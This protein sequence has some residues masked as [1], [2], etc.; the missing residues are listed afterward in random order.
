VHPAPPKLLA[1]I[2]R[3]EHHA[4]YQNSPKEKV[5]LA[6]LLSPDVLHFCRTYPQAT[7]IVRFRWD[8][9]GHIGKRYARFLDAL[10][11]NLRGSAL[12]PDMVH[13]CESH[14]KFRIARHFS[15]TDCHF[16]LRFSLKVEFEAELVKES[17]ERFVRPEDVDE[18]LKFFY[19]MH[20]EGI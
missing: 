13:I 8:V 20:E 17:L 1:K 7:V 2:R 18:W 9:K 5:E 11:Y 3:V 4:F 15:D 14:R 16:N 12:F 19:A 6:R 10:K